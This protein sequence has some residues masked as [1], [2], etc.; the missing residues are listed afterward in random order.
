VGV[1]VQGHVD[2]GVTEDL[3][4]DLHCLVG[5]HPQRGEGVSQGVKPRPFGQAGLLS[6]RLDGVVPGRL[7]RRSMRVRKD[8][9]TTGR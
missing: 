5:F 9:V 1:D 7:G 2:A 6:K 8:I 3:L 4:E